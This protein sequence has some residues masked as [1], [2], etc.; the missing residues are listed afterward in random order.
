IFTHQATPSV[1]TFELV[2]GPATSRVF[3]GSAPGRVQPGA[4]AVV[5]WPLAAGVAEQDDAVGLAL[6]PQPAVTRAAAAISAVASTVGGAGR[7]MVT[8]GMRRP[9]YSFTPSGRS[10]WP[11]TRRPRRSRPGPAAARPGGSPAGSSPGWPGPRRR[12][13]CSC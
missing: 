1:A 9:P 11:G 13:G 4:D 10:A 3:R 2:I 7:G 8:A 5:G 6:R 12:A